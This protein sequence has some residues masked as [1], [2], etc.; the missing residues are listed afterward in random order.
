M[1]QRGRF[2]GQRMQ[3]LPVLRGWFESAA[4][5]TYKSIG[6]A[7]PRNIGILR[8]HEESGLSLSKLHLV[9]ELE[10][11]LKLA[12]GNVLPADVFEMKSAKWL[13]RQ[14]HFDNQSQSEEN[15]TKLKSFLDSCSNPTLLGEPGP[16]GRQNISFDL[17]NDEAREFL[18]G[19]NFSDQED[20]TKPVAT[21]L[22]GTYY[23]NDIKGVKLVIMSR[24]PSDSKGL[25]TFGEYRTASEIVYS[26]RDGTVLHTSKITGLTSSNDAKFISGE[27]PSIQVHIFEMRQPG[28]TPT[29]EVGLAIAFPNTNRVT[30]R[31]ASNA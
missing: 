3:Y 10:G 17:T 16:S 24:N 31:K 25:S 9:F 13:F 21:D 27:V 26:R 20:K 14:T 4:L 2:Y 30:G 19:W 5:T 18:V 12:R 6:G 23:D 8:R 28:K 1:Q 22:L 29:T 15:L 7:E 11:D